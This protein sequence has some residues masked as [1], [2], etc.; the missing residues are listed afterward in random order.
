LKKR[1]NIPD[2]NAYLDRGSVTVFN[3][4]AII[5]CIGYLI[6]IIFNYE[7]LKILFYINLICILFTLFAY[8]LYHSGRST[9]KFSYG[10]IVYV[11]IASVLIDT[12]T[13]PLSP[14]RINF[15]LRDSLFVMIAITLASLLV[16]K[17]HALIISVLY[18]TTNLILTIITNNDFLKSSMLLIFLFV[19]G[20]SIIVYYFVGALEKSIL[21]IKTDSGT[22]SDQNETLNETNTMLEERQQQIEEQSEILAVQTEKLKKQSLQLAMKNRELK[23]LNKTKDRF[24]S[25]LAHDLKNPFSTILGLSDLLE[26]KYNV[27]SERKKIEFIRM[28]SA[29][30]QR[31]YSL[32]NNLLQWAMAQ[33]DAITYNPQR[34]ELSVLINKNLKFFIEG[35]AAKKIKIFE[36]AGSDCFVFADKNMLDSVIRNLLSNAI[37]FTPEEG[38]IHISCI[39]AN[40][41]IRVQISDTGV[42][43]DKKTLN[44]LFR[45]DKMH[46]ATGTSGETGTGLGLL[47]CKDFVE[48]NGGKIW[49]ASKMNAGSTFSFSL[50]A[51]G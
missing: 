41:E 13:N 3:V 7:P 1:N 11:A 45:I 15:F 21:V 19:T 16:G 38:D 10:I 8:I 4:S 36:S 20:F 43:M 26:K 18:L 28:L 25:I 35:C 5:I 23:Q 39:K 31:T 32:L 42:G 44:G 51:A 6:D 14:D 30:S 17:A 50:P 37:K 34:I 12:F 47:L 9:I 22:I 29:T 48:K 49:V 27:L 24:I 33:S 40:D 46:S 2:L